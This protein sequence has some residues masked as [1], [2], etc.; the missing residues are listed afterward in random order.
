MIY[1]ATILN[2]IFLIYFLCKYLSLRINDKWFICLIFFVSCFI[3]L[4]FNQ[5]GLNPINKLLMFFLLYGEVLI[6]FYDNWKKKTL[7][8]LLYYLIIGIG[9]PLPVFLIQ[10]L[11]IDQWIENP[12]ILMLMIIALSQVIYYASAAVVNYAYKSIKSNLSKRFYFLFIPLLIVL[13]F[14]FYFGDYNT[15]FTGDH[16]LLKI[17]LLCLP[18]IFIITLIQ[19]YIIKVSNLKKN[20]E[21]SKLNQE[22]L[23]S[24]YQYLLNQY[25]SN[26]NFLH[27]LLKTCT[28]LTVL[29]NNKKYK[30][31]EEEI[32]IL[33][34]ETYK[35][36]NTIYSNSLS[37]S[38][39]LNEK[40][41]ELT[42]NDIY[43]TTTLL[44]GDLKCLSSNQQVYLF[45]EMISAAINS[46]KNFN[47]RRYIIVKS[48][49]KEKSTIIQ[50]IFSNNSIEILS[51][52]KTITDEIDKRIN[53]ISNVKFDESNQT[54][55][56]IFSLNNASNES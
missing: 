14:L 3:V 23:E 22:L 30:E 36:F 5:N 28:N 15:L 48:L 37:L 29:I 1:I 35:K 46:C 33:S 32:Y 20:L 47:H 42:E 40:Q 54:I 16:I 26:F 25:N 24:K 50:F 11:R 45:N 39:V 49:M 12:L 2:I 27:D 9:E 18:V 31:L 7:F 38:I 34:D 56:V 6:V 4:I 43:V 8:F 52:V 10:N 44:D 51:K 21:I 41:Q 55:E 17:F 13:V 53:S 19:I